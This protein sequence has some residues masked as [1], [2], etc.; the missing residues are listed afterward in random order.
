[1]HKIRILLIIILI[2]IVTA[3]TLRS[4]ASVKDP[5]YDDLEGYD[6]VTALIKDG[7]TAQ[8]AEE[9][10]S[11][12]LRKENPAIYRLLVSQLHY[13]KGEWQKAYD[14]ADDVPTSEQFNYALL[15][16]AR[17]AFQLNAYGKCQ[18]SFSLVPMEAIAIENDFIWRAQCEYKTKMYPQAWQSLLRGQK[19]FS[20]FGIEREMIAFKVDLKMPHEALTQSLNWFAANAYL[21]GQILNVAEIFHQNNFPDYARAVLELGRAKFPMH[22][23]INL[24][25]SQLYFQKNLL[26]A[27]EEG[28]MRASF[29]DAKYFYHTAEMNRQLGN[30]ERSQYFNAFVRD[31]K[32]KLKQKI[33]TYVDAGKFPL[34]AS[35]E[36]VINRS[37]LSRDDEIRYALAYS[38]VKMGQTERPLQYLSSITKPEL[39]EKTTVLRKTLIDCQEK[40]DACRL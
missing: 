38:L 10:K 11:S 20:G 19:K 23:D 22:L 3:I 9:L 16:K 28:F 24:T 34:I 12:R 40:K 33:A 17:A 5:I 4:S 32:E 36:P 26:L 18:K 21:P 31:P 39:I 6:L 2:L 14:E 1:M 15:V 25:L 35:L 37:D 13:S 8:A 30:Y 29:S 27:A 7:K